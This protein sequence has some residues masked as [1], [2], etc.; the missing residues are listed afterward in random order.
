MQGILG[1]TII[2]F[3]HCV[4]SRVVLLGVA[5]YVLA[6]ALALALT[7]RPQTAEAGFAASGA[8]AAFDA[9]RASFSPEG[10]RI[11]SIQAISINAAI[12]LGFAITALVAATWLPAQ[13]RGG[14]LTFVLSKPIGRVSAVIGSLLGFWLVFLVLLA[15]Y[16]LCG[17]GALRLASATSEDPRDASRQLETVRTGGAFGFQSGE[18]KP[19]P[20][21]AILTST[22]HRAIWQFR[23]P[24]FGGRALE[25]GKLHCRFVAEIAKA[26]N[27]FVTHTDLLVFLTD[28]RTGNAVEQLRIIN[29][30][31]GQIVEFAIPAQKMPK[32]DFSIAVSPAVNGYKVICHKNWLR[33]VTSIQG[34]EWSYVKAFALALLG[35]TVFVSLTV[36]GSTFLSANVSIFFSTGAGALGACVGFFREYLQTLYATALGETT[37]VGPDG[38]HVLL[39][40]LRA[41]AEALGESVSIT[42]TQTASQVFNNVIFSALPDWQRF[43][44]ADFIVGRKDLPTAEFGHSLIYAG[45][46]C[47]VCVL[48]AA[49]AFGR[50]E[51]K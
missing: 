31:S 19:E 18:G 44:G 20:G 38:R 35:L 30:K 43:N 45:I 2:T 14:E 1:I 28:P 46:Y 33:V 39:T 50:R 40:H 4:R 23:S 25:G 12:F 49:F 42:I 10:Y 34:F 21:Y 37:L 22:A 29:A 47:A 26:D 32:G 6:M 8:G 36:G 11:R 13:I 9:E 27:E 41:G 5:A 51:L 48:V 24:Q 7:P 17:I 3:R 16:A 15:I